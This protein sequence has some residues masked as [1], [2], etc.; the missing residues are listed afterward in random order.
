MESEPWA[1]SI[2]NDTPIEKQPLQDGPVNEPESEV[3]RY[4]RTHNPKTRPKG[5][6]VRN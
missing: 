6:T 2:D 4:C 3:E 5:N 1:N